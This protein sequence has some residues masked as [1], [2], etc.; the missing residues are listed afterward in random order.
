[1]EAM[2]ELVELGLIWGREASGGGE[3][4]RGVRGKWGGGGDVDEVGQGVWVLA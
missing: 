2:E 3:R 1:M 4:V